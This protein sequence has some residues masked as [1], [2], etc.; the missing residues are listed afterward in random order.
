VENAGVPLVAI[1]ASAS[2]PVREFIQA[3]PA[4]S[5]FCYV[6]LERLSPDDS[7]ILDQPPGAQSTVKVTEM[8]N[9]AAVSPDTVFVI[10][11]GRSISLKDGRFGLHDDRNDT[12]LWS[13][14]DR[15]FATLAEDAGQSV[16]CVI[17]SETAGADGLKAIKAAGDIAVI[18]QRDPDHSEGL[19]QN[20]LEAGVVDFVLEA[21]AIPAKL[22]ELV[23]HRKS[24][25]ENDA[26]EAMEAELATVRAELTESNKQLRDAHNDIR[27]LCESTDIAALFLDT[28]LCLRG[29]TPKAAALFGLCASDKGCHFDEIAQRFVQDDLHADIWNVG[30]TLDPIEREVS[31]T[32]TN[33]RFTLLVRPYLTSDDRSDGYVL[34]FFN[35][36]Q[37]RQQEA[38]LDRN[39]RD[40]ARQ[41]AELETLYD[42]TPVGLSLL[43][44]DLRYLRINAE[45]A[46]LN[47]FTAEEHIGKT[48]AELLPEIDSM[49]AEMQ[50]Q[51]FATGNAL[52]GHEVRGK[53]PRDPEKARD[54]I[55]DYYPVFNDGEVFAVG[56]CVREVTEQKETQRQLVRNLARIKESEALLARV[57]DAAPAFIGMHEGPEHIY[58]YANPALMETLGNRQLIGKSIREAVPEIA[59]TAVL[60]K[61]DEVHQNGVPILEWEFAAEIDSGS[62]LRR[63]HYRQILQ[64]WYDEDGS[65]AGVL[66]FAYDITEIKN[67]QERQNLLLGELQHRVKNTLATILA[68]VRFTA[69]SS[70]NIEAME[71]TLTERLQAISRTHDLLTDGKWLKL[72]FRSIIRAELEPYETASP[73][74]ITVK[75]ADFELEPEDALAVS[76]A[77]HELITNS[78]KHGALADPHGIVE[79]VL[80]GQTDGNAGRFIWTEH[81]EHIREVGERP[82]G[83]GHFLL[84]QGVTAQVRGTAALEFG[85]GK[86]RYLLSF[87][88]H[89]DHGKQDRDGRK[90]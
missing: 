50:Q 39:A 29:F 57:F 83:F 28:Q 51:V 61:F 9:G 87:R 38:K 20:T 78:V 16:S 82:K 2:G 42:T 85:E 6:V 15:F 68:I 22:I 21:A 49:I 47:G 62:G 23:E 81:S 65:I 37:L 72:S 31:M 44:R 46:A 41:Y 33:E 60:K 17:M 8:T 24:Q 84:E 18:Q 19:Q 70:R 35:I 88:D 63:G 73:R 64:P 76:M 67:A 52:F 75:G 25:N 90:S 36:T 32:E 34:S 58:R 3:I 7:S 48:Q 40:L 56:S 1:G 4:G 79:I 12:D 69:R 53:T 55:V 66:S 11:A 45:L 30:D 10:P 14:I 26:L 54:W 71:R 86:L 74:N 13:P 89:E 59:D 77:I 80:E 5:G 43:D 27:N